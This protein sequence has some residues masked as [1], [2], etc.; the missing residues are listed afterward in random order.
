MREILFRGKLIGNRQWIEGHYIKH[1]S[2]K[3]CVSTDDPKTK[4]LIACDGFCDWGF[5]PPMQAFEVLPETIGQYT[6]LKD[7]NGRRIFEGDVVEYIGRKYHV[8]MAEERRGWWPFACGDGCG[9]CE[10]DTIAP[11]DCVV[12]GNVHDNPG[13]LNEV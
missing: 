1:D 7:K 11:S 5:E 4:F 9:C 3:A 10:D 12:I 2:V 8:E 13:L 6:G